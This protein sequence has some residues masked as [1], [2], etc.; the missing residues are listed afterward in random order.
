MKNLKSISTFKNESINV[1]DLKN[2]SGGRG[3]GITA[4]SERI[5][6]VC[7]SSPG[8]TKGNC[9]C[10]FKLDGTWNPYPGSAG[11]PVLCD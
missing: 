8:D 6:N 10:G 9:D 11:Y 2:V 3:V 5:E 7:T 4:D 1:I